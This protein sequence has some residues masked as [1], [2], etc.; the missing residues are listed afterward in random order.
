MSK[1]RVE[2]L[3]T[4]LLIFGL[5]RRVTVAEVQALLG[6]CRLAAVHLLA[7]PGDHD[8]AVGVVHLPHDRVLAFRLADR[9]NQRRLHGR[10]LQSWVPAMAWS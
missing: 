3:E 6:S 9:I 1:S 4:R 7:Q 10:R 8:E 2:T 5:S